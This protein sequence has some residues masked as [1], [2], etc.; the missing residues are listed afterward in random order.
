MAKQFDPIEPAR[1]GSDSGAAISSP[2]PLIF[3]AAA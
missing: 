1:A 2:N 3:R